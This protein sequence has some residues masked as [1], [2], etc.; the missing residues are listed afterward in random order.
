M[1]H[2]VDS[3]MA[4]Y[5]IVGELISH[6]ASPSVVDDNVE[7]I[8][9]VLDLLSDILDLLP[10]TQVALQPGDSLGRV[11]S[12]FLGHG[13]SGAVDDVL[14]DGE[15]EELG[16]VATEQS[17]CH[18]E[19]YTLAAPGHDGNFAGQVWSLLETELASA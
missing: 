4:I 2:M 9:C 14:G 10:V 5:T 7:P 8:R 17:V 1:A 12:H 6:D 11:V 18:A 13:L 15:D 19:A 3:H 16:D